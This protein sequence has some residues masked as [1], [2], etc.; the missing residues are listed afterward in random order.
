MKAIQLRYAGLLA[1]TFLMSC[2]IFDADDKNII[3]LRVINNS[4]VVLESF[5]AY[6]ITFGDIDSYQKSDFQSTEQPVALY[7]SG[8]HQI[9]FR[10]NAKAFRCYGPLASN[11]NYTVIIEENTENGLFDV[12]VE[13]DSR[14]VLTELFFLDLDGG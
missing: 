10:A 6:S 9:S 14:N 5:W 7:R 12:Y 4:G 1:C 13:G 2:S 11:G 3:H 8:S